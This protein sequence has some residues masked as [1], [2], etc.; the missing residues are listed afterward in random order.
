LCL[1]VVTGC[2][3]NP[4]SGPEVL[5][6]QQARRGGVLT[7]LDDRTIST[8]DPQSIADPGDAALA[9]RLFLRTLTT[10][11][12]PLAEGTAG[13]GV[14]ATQLV[15]DL[16]VGPGT[17]TDGGKSWSLLLR[18]GV[19]WQDGR[20]VSCEDV[21]YGVSR[22]FAKDRVGGTRYAVRYLDVPRVAAGPR[23]GDP[24]Y[25]GPADTEGQAGFD[26]AIACTGH[27]VTFHL[28]QQVPDFPDLLTLPEF[29]P[30]RE[31]IDERTDD[32]FTVFS[33]G[34]YILEGN[35]HTGRGGKFTRNYNW[36]PLVDPVREANPDTVRYVESVPGDQVVT[37][38][39]SAEGD[40]RFALAAR[41]VPAARTGAVD[42]DSTLKPRLAVVPQGS[43]DYLVVRARS[44]ALADPVVRRAFALATDRA[45]YVAA[46]GGPSA[47]RLA[48]ALIP[49]DVD[50]SATVNPLGAPDGGDPTR[51]AALLRQ[52][53]VTAPVTVRLAVVQDTASQAAAAAL[54]GGWKRAGFAVVVVPVP[55][56]EVLR[57]RNPGSTGDVDVVL[58]TRHLDWRSGAA[59][60]PPVLG[61]D[62]DPAG[63]TQ[64]VSQDL[65]VAVARALAT[66]NRPDR[67]LAWAKV[68]DLVVG[69]GTV[70]PLGER[71]HL[72]LRGPLVQRYAGNPLAGAV[73]LA[74]VAVRP[75]S[76]IP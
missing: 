6:P 53:K 48:T 14:D 66:P 10:Y 20:Q 60:V 9:S 55:A 22:T 39:R 35:W 40:D 49:R 28:R 50:R 26:A 76:D 33:D 59:I 54:V 30:Y 24:L 15:G 73:D 57:L 71:V 18:T 74:A 3:T 43:V 21:R 75:L 1:F 64:G 52:A 41:P 69:R 23:A 68:S 46:A 4:S 61:L 19:L 34:P 44:A 25:F 65:V 72:L 38:L 45:A 47:V 62:V 8:W 13:P 32:R 42:A 67:E 56:A 36:L 37:R 17:T 27:I 7:V 58:S 31:D 51:S 12:P 63:A 29:A 11:L 16:A 2:V 5:T 70:I